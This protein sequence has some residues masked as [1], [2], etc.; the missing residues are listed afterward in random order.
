VD[1]TTTPP[2][3]KEPGIEE[4]LEIVVALA[5]VVEKVRDVD[6]LVAAL[7]EAAALAARHV[8]FHMVVINLARPAQNDFPAAV[9]EGAQSNSDVLIGTAVSTREAHVILDPRFERHGCHLILAGEL[10]WDAH[11]EAPMYVPDL[12][13]DGDPRRWDPDDALVMALRARDGELLGLMWLDEPLDGLRPSDAQLRL[14]ALI[15]RHAANA[16]EEATEALRAREHRLALTELLSTSTRL[17]EQDLEGI[18][19]AVCTGIGQALAF[20]RVAVTLRPGA[21]LGPPRAAVGYTAEQLTAWPAYE[22]FERLLDPAFERAGCYLVTAEEAA[23][24]ISVPPAEALH[25]RLNGEG[26]RAWSRHWLLVPLREPGG[27]VLGIVWVDD[28]IDRLLPDEDRLRALRLFADQA[29]TAVVAARRREELRTLARVDPL[30]GLPN[31]VA[32]LERLERDRRVAATRGRVPAPVLLLLDLDAFKQI[33][34]TQGHVVG[35]LALRNVADTL[36]MHMR[37]G[38]A[39]FR[40]SGDEFA[41]V[42]AE[43]SEAGADAAAQRLARGLAAQGLRASFGSATVGPHDTPATLMARA[44][45]QL[46]A[47]KRARAATRREAA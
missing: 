46:V 20:S 38:D 29:T 39:A 17:H 45:A 7:G 2:P 22:E 18:L 8:G 42:L 1:S 25:S 16:I 19:T 43:T 28:P 33:N 12:P 26:P 36:R 9:I 31:R 44:D 10:D 35:D 3:W 40:I 24:R 21:G 4:S 47:R 30:T 11:W 27:E 13:S 41:M 15:A 32:L 6:D 14:A 37:E 34:D 5:H 23:E